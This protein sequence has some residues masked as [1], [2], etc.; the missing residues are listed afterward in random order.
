MIKTLVEGVIL[1]LTTGTA[2]LVTCS[3]IYLPYL[4]SED[5]KL[6]KSIY[7]VLEI[8]AGRFVSYLAFGAIAGYT[9]AQIASVNR[10]LFTSIAYILLSAYLVLSAV[11]TNKK[12]KSC[13]VPKMAR[14]TQSGIILGILT[15]I[16]FCPSFLIA[17]S[18]AVDLGG[19]FSGMML[20]LGFFFGTS[21]FLL[22]LAFIGQISKV[23]KMKMVAQYASILVAI[24][25][26][27]SGV[28]GLVHYFEHKK[29]D[30]Q[31]SRLVEAFN[32][33]IPLAVIASEENSTYFKTL[34]DSLINYTPSSVHYFQYNKTILDSINKLS[35]TVLVIDSSILNESF[36]NY[37][38]FQ[39][40]PDYDLSRM[41]KFMKFYT[42]KTR[43][44]LHWEFIE[45]EEGSHKH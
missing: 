10:E 22:P 19:A 3:P 36:D 42:F 31:P 9:G 4:I 39:V 25:F 28:K 26:T 29:L 33:N 27:F 32:P 38:Y 16:N 18:K 17:L 12:A 41:L 7:A 21:I 24:W 43:T 5:R 40:E 45:K 15:G 2:C 11:R 37:D 13:H 23:S 6:S 8:S 34:Q 30:A 35:E 20:F 14:F 1:G 44:H